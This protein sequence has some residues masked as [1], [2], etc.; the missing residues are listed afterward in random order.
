LQPVGGCGEREISRR[1]ETLGQ[2]NRGFVEGLV[3]GEVTEHAESIRE[4]HRVRML[5][6][7][8]AEPQPVFPALDRKSA[9]QSAEE[10]EIAFLHLDS[11]VPD[12]EHERASGVGIQI[13][14][15]HSLDFSQVQSRALVRRVGLIVRP[16][17]ERLAD[18]GN[19]RIHH[20][21]KAVRGSYE[22]RDCHCPST[23][24]VGSAS[25][26]A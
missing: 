26:Y 16:A 8:L 23:E 4:R 10:L 1:W 19:I 22:Q 13:G 2:L 18:H 15:E 12:R 7:Q 24:H 9:R 21:G 5:R 14:I 17:D 11:F 6:V 20:A 3:T 25:Q